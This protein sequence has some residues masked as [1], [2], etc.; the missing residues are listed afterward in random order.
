MKAADK[1]LSKRYARAYMDLDGAAFD[2]HGAAAAKERIAELEKIYAAASQYRR[3]LLHP[4][5]GFDEKNE[6][7]TRLLCSGTVG[8]VIKAYDL[9]TAKYPLAAQAASFV[10]L[11]LKENR[12]Y[13][14][15]TVIGDCMKVYNV[16]AGLA[17]AEVASRHPLGEE[18]LKHI[19]K[20]LS[21]ATG[22]TVN[23]TQ[24]VS[25]RVIGGMEI[26]MGDLLIDDTVKGRLD[27][28]KKTILSF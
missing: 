3:L 18:E 21:S 10:R 5:V 9:E 4:L 23:V 15:E 1:T 7:L 26:R 14:L 27:R 17:R 25:E 12:F 20:S 6:I 16:Y 22:K 11:L 2:K 8:D 24:V 13:L 19:G 28:L